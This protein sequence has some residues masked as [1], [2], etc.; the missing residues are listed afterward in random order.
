MGEMSNDELSIFF[1]R[2][3]DKYSKKWITRWNT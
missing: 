2:I 3:I 1:D